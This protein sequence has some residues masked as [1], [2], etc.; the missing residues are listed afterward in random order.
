MQYPIQ[1]IGECELLVCVNIHFL[2]AAII[3]NFTNH[4][5]NGEII[6]GVVSV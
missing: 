1:V 2:C 6:C 4:T 5:K 3:Y